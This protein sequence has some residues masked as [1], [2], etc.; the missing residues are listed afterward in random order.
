MS[1]IEKCVSL[2]E[3]NDSVCHVCVSG[4][5]S[6]SS[7][8]NIERH[9]LACGCTASLSLRYPLTHTFSHTNQCMTHCVETL[10]SCKL[11]MNFT[12]SVSGVCELNI[13]SYCATKTFVFE[14]SCQ[15]Q[16]LFQPVMFQRT[17][18]LHSSL[19]LGQSASVYGNFSL[20]FLD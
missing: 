17:F 5:W 13:C 18:V 8:V 6:T 1:E 2:P 4:E 20:T 3:R 9:L 12:R 15:A 7:S 10:K 16:S 19:Q 11:N 14:E